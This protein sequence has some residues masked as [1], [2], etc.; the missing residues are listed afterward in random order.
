MC[1]PPGTVFIMLFRSD[2]QMKYLILFEFKISSTWRTPMSSVCSEWV[3]VWM[4]SWSE[5]NRNN[6]VSGTQAPLLTILRFLFF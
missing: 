3:V 4:I 2:L 6:S 5:L 1:K